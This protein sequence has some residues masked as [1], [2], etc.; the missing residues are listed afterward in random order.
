MN[1]E[2]DF[3]PDV[4]D[5]TNKMKEG[6]GIIL[7][8]LIEESGYRYNKKN[9]LKTSRDVIH[10][11]FTM[12]KRIPAKRPRIV[13]R[14]KDFV[15]PDKYQ[16][17]L[18]QLIEKFERGDDLYPYLTKTIRALD[19]SDG[20][21][22]DWDMYHFHLGETIEKGFITRT[23]HI[24]YAIVK[25]DDVYLIIIAPHGK[26]I[27]DHIAWSNI[28]LV[29]IAHDNWPNIFSAPLGRRKEDSSGSGEDE[30]VSE[31]NQFIED[32]RLE[33]L[34][35]LGENASEEEVE[36]KQEEIDNLMG[37]SIFL[38]PLTA[39]TSASEVHYE[40]RK[41]GINVP[42]AMKDG[43]VHMGLGMGITCSGDSA[44]ASFRMA[45]FMRRING[46]SRNIKQ[47]IEESAIN[48]LELRYSLVTTVQKE[49]SVE[50]GL[51]RELS[52]QYS[53][54]NTDVSKYCCYYPLRAFMRLTR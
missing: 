41:S 18:D 28:D 13:H 52:I 23:K 17:G 26:D 3:S 45:G 31:S 54:E 9:S 46:I 2:L 7:R 39:S 19:F 27:E 20:L 33:H 43:T 36:K 38:L 42:I 6:I 25:D 14:A 32:L 49:D 44:E 37:T 16:K 30:I 15:C 34:K 4:K 51:V 29:Q 12:E 48:N 35:D 11:F 22:F 53:T 24:L 50:I 21:L 40:L 1:L 10:M 8:K 47:D 5:I